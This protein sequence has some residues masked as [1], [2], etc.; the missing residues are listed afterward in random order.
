MHL[1]LM[2][3]V[4][5]CGKPIRQLKIMQGIQDG[6]NIIEIMKELEYRRMCCRNCILSSPLVVELMK[7]AEYQKAPEAFIT[8]LGLAETSPISSGIVISQQIDASNL[9]R[10]SATNARLE[11]MGPGPIDAYALAIEREQEK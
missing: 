2:P 4:C 5:S 9:N 10:Y 7:K 1:Q 8:S 6:R 11:E 3:I